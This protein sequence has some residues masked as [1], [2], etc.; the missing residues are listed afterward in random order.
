MNAIMTVRV[1]KI[2]NL[3][4]TIYERINMIPFELFFEE[5]FP[6]ETISSGDRV[7]N[8]KGAVHKREFN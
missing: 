6:T 1:P 7:L 2:K 4:A 8:W 5:I 3:P